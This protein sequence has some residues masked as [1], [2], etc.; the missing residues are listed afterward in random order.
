[1]IHE[2]PWLRETYLP[3]QKAIEEH[4]NAHA[5]LIQGDT[6]VLDVLYLLSF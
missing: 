3:L 4:K 1:M 5:F 6:G 2:Y